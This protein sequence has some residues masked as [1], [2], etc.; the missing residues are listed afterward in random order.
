MITL[1]RSRSGW[2]LGSGSGSVVSSAQPEIFF[3]SS[4]R[5][6]AS[7]STTGPREQLMR[8]AVGFISDRASSPIIFRLGRKRRM[9]RDEIRVAQQIL[10]FRLLAGSVELCFLDV[11]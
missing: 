7:V 1:S 5:T 6:S 9:Q 4:A 8:N 3:A 2:G 10:E 11:G